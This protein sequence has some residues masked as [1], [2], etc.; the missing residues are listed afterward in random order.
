MRISKTVSFTLPPDMLARATKLAKEE[1]RTMSELLREAF[2]IYEFEKSLRGLQKYGRKQAEK[3][4]ITED[5]VVDAVKSVRKELWPAYKKKH[6]ISPAKPSKKSAKK[7][8][9]KRS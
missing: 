7:T 1:N 2:R 9:K 6:G 4:G 8:S 3:T 5:D